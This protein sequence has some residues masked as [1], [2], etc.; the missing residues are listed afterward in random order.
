MTAEGAAVYAAV[1]QQDGEVVC[2]GS[3]AQVWPAVTVE[4]EPEAGD[5]VDEALLGTVELEDGSLQV[6][7]DD[8][9]LHTF[10]SD[11]ETGDVAGHGSADRWWV[12]GPDG[13]LIDAPDPDEED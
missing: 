13:E 12:V 9:P 8:A 6:V 5:G 1:D 3:C 7:Y 4:G 2:T 11:R 10:V